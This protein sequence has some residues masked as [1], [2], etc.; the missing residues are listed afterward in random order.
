MVFEIN[1]AMIA[2]S[3][4][5]LRPLFRW[6]A[7][8]FRSNSEVTERD[9]VE[10]RM[11]ELR[12]PNTAPFEMGE[13]ILQP[14][15]PLHIN[16]EYTFA[17]ERASMSET[18]QRNSYADGESWPENDRPTSMAKSANSRYGF[19]DVPSTVSSN[20]MDGP[21][22]W[23]ITLGPFLTDSNAYKDKE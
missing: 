21:D 14:E 20:G 18:S 19:G 6:T 5:M 9:K 1:L 7:Q 16:V 3:L 4:P 23:N 13:Y 17:V 11:R 12:D 22:E 15:E 2:T 8:R 10:Y